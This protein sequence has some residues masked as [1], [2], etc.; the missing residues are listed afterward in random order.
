MVSTAIFAAGHWRRRDP[1]EGLTPAMREAI[2]QDSPF[3]LVGGVYRVP[4]RSVVHAP[5]TL[6]ALAARGLVEL[7]LPRLE[8]PLAAYRLTRRGRDIAAEIA[9]RA[10]SR[11]RLQ[12]A[13]DG[14]RHPA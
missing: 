6:A 10:A 5:A 2:A 9:R 4:S 1:L 13:A 14:A 3:T 12:G 8:R 11:A 7:R